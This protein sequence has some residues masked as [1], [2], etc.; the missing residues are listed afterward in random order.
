VS[1]SVDLATAGK[2][3]AIDEELEE[4]TVL[5]E[6]AFVDRRVAEELEELLDESSFVD[7]RG[8]EG[9]GS[10]VTKL[11]VLSEQGEP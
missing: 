1:K 9:L 2:L 7:R 5:D 8:A 11:L 4:F 6:S 3:V 10:R